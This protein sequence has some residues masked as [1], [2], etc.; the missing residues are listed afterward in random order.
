MTT[1]IAPDALFASPADDPLLRLPLADLVSQTEER[2][3]QGDLFRRAA[4]S[5]F[6]RQRWRAAGIRPEQLQGRAGLRRLPFVDGADLIA[7][8]DSGNGF[9]KALLTRPRIWVTSRGT[10]GPKKWLPLTLADTAHWFARVRRVSEMLGVEPDVPAPTLILAINEPMP[11][12]RN[13]VPYLWE[14][15]DY[16][17]GGQRLEFIIAAMQMLPHNHWD[18][19]VVQKQPQWLMASVDDARRLAQ[20]L[21]MEAS[22]ALPGLR[23]GIFWGQPLDGPAGARAELETTY[24]L[25]ETFSLYLSAECREMYA[26]CP[27][28]AGLHLWMDGAIHEII[29]DGHAPAGHEPT[30]T[31]FVDQASPGTEGEY[32]VTTFAEALPLIRYRTGD[33]IRVLDTAPCVCGITHPRVLFTGRTTGSEA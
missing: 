26:E 27:A 5:S 20:E 17:T 14:R 7:L 32:V 33:R 15:A 8:A 23:R 16:L 12:V 30:E 31:L 22:Q 4:R 29:P 19:F 1:S 24:G 2:L 25:P 13:A 6:Y 11:R 21:E 28:H 9:R 10:T 3:D 18:R